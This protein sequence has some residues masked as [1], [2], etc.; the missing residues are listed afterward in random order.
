MKTPVNSRRA[1]FLQEMLDAFEAGDSAKMM[2]VANGW[3]VTLWPIQWWV[4]GNEE[5]SECDQAALGEMGKS[6]KRVMGRGFSGQRLSLV[7]A[8]QS[9][10]LGQIWQTCLQRLSPEAKSKFGSLLEFMDLSE[11]DTLDARYAHEVLE[12]LRKIIARIRDLDKIPALSIPNRAVQLAF[13][14]AHRCYLYGFRKGCV[15]LCRSTAEAA[16][17]EALIS[18][19]EKIRRNAEFNE[20]LRLPA[21]ETLLGDLYSSAIEIRIA[22]KHAVHYADIFDEEYPTPKIKEVV[23]KTRRVVEHLYRIGQEVPSSPSM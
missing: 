19:G 16:L 14:E 10:E 22:G 20:M 15:A 6:L 11:L 13:E 5:L 2:D 9:G 8:F 21:A 4:E 23:I 7:P 17:N 18:R 3:Q 12:V 1:V